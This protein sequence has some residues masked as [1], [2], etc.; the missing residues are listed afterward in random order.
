MTRTIKPG[1]VYVGHSAPLGGE[2]ISFSII[3]EIKDEYVYYLNVF[4]NDFINITNEKMEI[5]G[6]C[7][8]HS[9]VKNH[10]RAHAV[11]KSLFETSDDLWRKYH[12]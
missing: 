9:R 4:T 12:K 7:K 8:Y 3:N 10:K 6:F 2:T 5:K 1:L 11:I